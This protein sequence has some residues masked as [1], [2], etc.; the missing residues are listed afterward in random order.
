VSAGKYLQAGYRSN[1]TYQYKSASNYWEISA[2]FPVSISSSYVQGS[3]SG[4]LGGLK[5]NNWY[6]IFMVG[7]NTA[8]IVVLPY[9][10]I[11]SVDYNASNSGKTTI[12]LAGQDPSAS[13]ETGLLTSN[14]QWNSYQLIKCSLDFF[15]G[16]VM[17]ISGTTSGTPYDQIVIDGNQSI[18]NNLISGDLFQLVPPSTAPCVYLGSIRIISSTTL[19][20][21]VKSR[22]RYSWTRSPQLISGNTST[23]ITPSDTYVGTA[24]SPLAYK[25]WLGT[26]TDETSN[27]RARHRHLLYSSDGSLILSHDFGEGGTT[28]NYTYTR[29]ESNTEWVFSQVQTIKNCFI[30]SDS[31]GTGYAVQGFWGFRIFAFEE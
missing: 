5:A 21:F 12:V 22:W 19:F 4:I 7:P 8:D 17:T 9:I 24:V 26:R 31:A 23:T 30:S 25:A 20:R 2:N 18:T 3:S 1:R 10:R 15:N 14:G 6:S 16:N 27:S 13:P 28:G 11:W 29:W